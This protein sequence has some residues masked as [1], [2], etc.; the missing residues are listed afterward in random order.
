MTRRLAPPR[1]LPLPLA[2]VLVGACGTPPAGPAAPSAEGDPAADPPGAPGPAAVHVPPVPTG[3]RSRT[4]L[5]QPVAERPPAPPPPLAAGSA[6]AAERA[7]GD[8]AVP[9]PRSARADDPGSRGNGLDA[10]KVRE[11]I[12]AAQGRIRHCFDRLRQGSPRVTEARVSV[13]LEIAPAGNVEEV[14][15]TGCA[16]DDDTFASCVRA[17][18]RSLDF[19][20][21]SAP[22][23]TT[24][25]FVFSVA[26]GEQ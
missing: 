13:R 15:V 21:A 22:T 12:H 7:V 3:V 20:P 4:L 26:S 10:F 14:E 17:L 11:V 6:P 8:G 16:P 24:Y 18:V 9:E 2:I 1:L 19:P 5:T 23:V 25:P